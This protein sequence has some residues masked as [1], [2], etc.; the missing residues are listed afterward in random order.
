MSAIVVELVSLVM[1]SFLKVV[2]YRVPLKA[3]GMGV[4]AS[5]SAIL[6]SRSLPDYFSGWRS[7]TLVLSSCLYRR[8]S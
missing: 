4:R 5:R 7:T 3:G 8:S 1:G 6:L 2:S